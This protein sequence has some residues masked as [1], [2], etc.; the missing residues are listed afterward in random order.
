M[1]GFK[2]QSLYKDAIDKIFDRKLLLTDIQRNFI[3][4]SEQIEMLF[5]SIMRGYPINSF[6]FW[7]I[8]NDK[9]KTG[10]KFY[11]FIR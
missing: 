4:K 1:L 9:I 3:W 6:M 11:E 2:L 7:K 10:Y 5:D 8:N